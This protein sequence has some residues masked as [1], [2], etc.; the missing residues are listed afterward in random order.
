MPRRAG[1]HPDKSGWG[2]HKVSNNIMKILFIHQHYYPELVGT[3]RRATEMCELLS[4]NGHNITVITSYPKRHY[5]LSQH[6]TIKREEIHN[7]VRILRLNQF[8]I[9]KG[10]PLIRMLSYF[11]F[12]AISLLKA[13]KLRKDMHLCLSITPLT[14]G[15][16]GALLHK[17]FKV[18]HHFDITDILPELGIVAGMLKNRVLIYLLRKVELFVY[19]NTNTFSVVTESMGEYIQGRLKYKREMI[20]APDWVDEDLFRRNRDRYKSQIIKKYSF[21]SKKIILFEGNVGKLQNLAIIT[22]VINILNDKGVKDFVFLLVGD[23]I[24]LEKIKKE[25]A[26]KNINQIIFTGR[27]PREYLPS[28]LNISDILFSNYLNN[29]HLEMYIPGKMYEYITANKPIIMGASG[30]CERFIKSNNLG[31]SVEPSNPLKIAEAIIRIFNKE[32]KLSSNND[33][34]VKQCSSEYIINKLNDFLVLNYGNKK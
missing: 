2:L 8:F 30:E 22:D 34:L 31:I 3:G 6:G 13:I 16:S 7:G 14:S 23:G 21:E 1:F 17:I 25:A 20:C 24:E 10:N 12:F 18:P 32:I 27:V 26:S 33:N 11:E 28:F 19:K 15:I 4:R 9:P 5:H 29:K